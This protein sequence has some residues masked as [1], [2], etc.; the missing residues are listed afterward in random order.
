MW[1]AGRVRLSSSLRGLASLAPSD[2]RRGGH[3]RGEREGQEAP[4]GVFSY[5][6]RQRPVLIVV[7]QKA[8]A[9]FQAP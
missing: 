2:L 8:N 6:C 1:R 9:W 7:E 3:A 5:S 4:L